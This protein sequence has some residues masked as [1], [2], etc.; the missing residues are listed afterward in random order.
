MNINSFNPPRS[1]AREIAHSQFTDEEMK[2]GYKDLV[3]IHRI[4]ELTE[5]GIKSRSSY[6]IDHYFHRHTTCQSSAI[7]SPITLR[8]P[9]SLSSVCVQGSGEFAEPS[10]TAGAQYTADTIV[11][12]HVL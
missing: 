6:L 8:G 12:T 5:G 7:G 2:E 3:S 1:S 4:K 9:S 10:V 11:W